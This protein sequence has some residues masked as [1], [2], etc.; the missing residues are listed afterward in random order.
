MNLET[1]MLP[2]KHVLDTKSAVMVYIV[3]AASHD[4]KIGYLVVKRCFDVIVSFF[5]GMILLI[6]MLLIALIIRLDSPGPALFRQ[7]RLGR[8][9]KAFVMLKFRSMRLDAEINGPKWA[10]SEDERCTNVGRVLRKFRLDEIPQLWNI[11]CGQMSFVGPRPE[12]AY[13]YNEFEKYIHGFKNRL[14]VKPGLTGWAQVNGGYDLKP[15]K[16]VLYDMKYIENQSI[17]LDLVCILKTVKLFFTHEG[18]R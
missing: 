4:T 6:P 7:E 11:F 3:P 5:C 15:E 1:T 2:E 8:E 10:E 13:F 16:K 12:R 17:V 18:A 9:G 14:A